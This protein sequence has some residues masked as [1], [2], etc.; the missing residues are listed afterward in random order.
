M[1]PPVNAYGP[2]RCSISSKGSALPDVPCEFVTHFSVVQQLLRMI[3]DL[4]RCK[5]VIKHLQ[6]VYAAKYV[7][8][9]ANDQRGRTIPDMHQKY[10][11]SA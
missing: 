10:I 2:N 8:I 4:I 6:V 5:R 1:P 3:F 7:Q 11:F 9:C